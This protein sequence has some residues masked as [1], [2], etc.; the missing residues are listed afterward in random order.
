MEYPSDPFAAGN[1]VRLRKPYKPGTWP[2]ER[3]KGMASREEWDVWA[4]YTHGIVAE[5]LE[6]ALPHRF[7]G[8]PIS[9]PVRRVS[10]HLYDPERAL[11]YIPHGFTVPTYVDF[12]VDEL[13]PHKIASDKGYATLPDM[14]S[15]EA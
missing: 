12:H 7:E 14:D 10:L 4:G 8:H 11:L 3:P 13:R 6:R 5:V 2:Q 9:G 1:I 15:A